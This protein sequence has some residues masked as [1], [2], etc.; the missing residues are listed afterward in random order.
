MAVFFRTTLYKVHI[1]SLHTS[2]MNIC[3]I[4]KYFF[5]LSIALCNTLGGTDVKVIAKLQWFKWYI[6]RLSS[7]Q[8]YQFSNS[9]NLKFIG[10]NFLFFAHFSFKIRNLKKRFICYVLSAVRFSVSAHLGRRVGHSASKLGCHI[11]CVNFIY[12]L[13]RELIVH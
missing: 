7:S 4:L 3:F 12:K 11:M 8:C 10:E 6:G 13:C 5:L 9:N 2:L 1:L